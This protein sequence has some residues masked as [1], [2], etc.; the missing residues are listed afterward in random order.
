V[1]R[2]PRFAQ[3]I[4]VALVVLVMSFFAF[5]RKNLSRDD[6]LEDGWTWGLTVKSGSVTCDKGISEPMIGFTP[7]DSEVTYA[8]SSNAVADARA[9]GDSKFTY[10]QLG[11]IWDGR[12]PFRPFLDAAWRAC[13]WEDGAPDYEARTVMGNAYQGH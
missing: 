10:A 4:V 11:D 7:T 2:F 6:A 3:L 5:G 1:V 8:L 9:V 13:G 12:S